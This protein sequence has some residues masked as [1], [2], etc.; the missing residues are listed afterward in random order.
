M[1]DKVFEISRSP[2]YN[3]HLRELT[4][5][6]YKIFDK[7]KSAGSCVA[8]FANKSAANYVPNYQLANELHKQIIRKFKR[9]KEYT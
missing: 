1:R 5:M 7:K 4:S 8:T 9:R 3:G 6:V 2:K